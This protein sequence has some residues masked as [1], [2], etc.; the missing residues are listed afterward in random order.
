MNEHLTTTLLVAFGITSYSLEIV[1]NLCSHWNDAGL[2]LK[3]FCINAASSHLTPSPPPRSSPML[4]D[5]P[6]EIWRIIF[7]YLPTQLMS[8]INH[9]ELSAESLWKNCTF[10]GPHATRDFPTLPQYMDRVIPCRLWKPELKPS[11][12]ALAVVQVCRTWYDLGLEFLYHTVAFRLKSHFDILRVTLAPPNG[13]GRFVRRVSIVCPELGLPDYIRP[14][15]NCC[16]N[17]EDFEA[18]NM[19]PSRQ[20]FPSPSS[21]RHCFFYNRDSQPRFGVTPIDMSP[22]TNLQALHLV[23]V[24]STKQPPPVLPKLA[25]L[26][27]KCDSGSA[28]YYKHV[29]N[30]TLPSLRVLV[31]QWI[32]TPF[33]HDLCKAFAQT[34]ELL[35]VIQYDHW[36]MT[37][38]TLEMPML[39]HLVINW[40]PPFPG[41]RP[42]FNLKRHFHSLPSLTAAHID[43]L[44]RAL[45][46]ARGFGVIAAEIENEMGMLGMLDSDSPLA[47]QMKTLYVGARIEN[48]KGRALEKS[49]AKTAA[50][51]W[52][53]RGRDGIWKVVDDGQL[54]LAEPVTA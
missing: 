45:G 10:P 54:L 24:A 35:E 38:A 37:L 31:C 11:S 6:S 17:I 52:V 3:T 19:Y 32:N 42:K 16:P 40:I 30:W 5:L 39:K 2:V 4:A 33:L 51:G 53:L 34:V 27:L 46:N 43:N 15:L 36:P 22:F 9:S 20:L 26:V 18:H 48:V 25:V 21:I 28:Y 12:E 23:V 50:V 8:P 44:D 1:P 29:T 7:S 13:R 14:I 47:P 41:Y 49:F